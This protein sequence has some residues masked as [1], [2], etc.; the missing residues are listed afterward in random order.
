[1]KYIVLTFK[2]KIEKSKEIPRNLFFL[3]FPA[4]FQKL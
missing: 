2:G 4:I 3:T 1:M